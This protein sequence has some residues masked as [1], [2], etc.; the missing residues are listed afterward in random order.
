[1][2]AVHHSGFPQPA[3]RTENNLEHNAFPP[4]LTPVRNMKLAITL[5]LG[6]A[7]QLAQ[8]IP[9]AAALSSS[10]HTVAQTCCCTGSQSC[11]CM[12]DGEPIQKPS[13]APIHS[14]NEVKIPAMKS[15]DTLVSVRVSR[16]IPSFST[17]EIAL[18]ME[19]IVGFTGVRLSVAFC[20][21]VI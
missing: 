9:V 13:P 3:N 21:F 1:M 2:Q 5:I 12:D 4:T 7:F 15:T 8:V 18:P 11:P 10:C 20:S 19:P 16:Q 17:V 6:L 14:G